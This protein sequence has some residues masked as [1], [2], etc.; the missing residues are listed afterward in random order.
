MIYNK[1]FAVCIV[2]YLGFSQSILS[3]EKD[4]GEVPF[5]VIEQVPVYKG[6]EKFTS[7]L[8][9]KQCMSDKISQLVSKEFDLNVAR[10]LDLEHESIERI[11]VVFKI[12]TKGKVTKIRARA[13]HPKLE[14]EAIRVIKLIPNMKPGLLK[15]KPVIVPYSLPILFNVDNPKSLSKTDEVKFPIHKRCAKTFSYEQQKACTT[16]KIMDFIK[17]S[18]DYELAS[19]LFPTENSTQFQVSFIIDKKGE[20]KNIKA[21]AHKREMAAE[22]IRTLKRLPK[23]KAPGYKNGKP[24]DTPFSFLMT[25]YFD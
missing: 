14:T 3:Q 15:G 24:V 21:K 11:N 9:R 5:S 17:V 18:I 2:L 4:E 22:A 6:C 8:E 23:L 7:N 19:D 12:N 1:I 25:I 13:S 10:K 16:E 20:I